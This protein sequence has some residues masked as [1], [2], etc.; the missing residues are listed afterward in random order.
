MYRIIDLITVYSVWCLAL[1]GQ[2]CRKIHLAWYP[3][4]YRPMEKSSRRNLY[5]P[6]YSLPIS[7]WSEVFRG[8]ECEWLWIY[9]RSWNK[10][11]S[12]L[13]LIYENIF[14]LQVYI[15]SHWIYE[16]T[17]SKSMFNEWMWGEHDVCY[18]GSNEVE[19]IR[20]T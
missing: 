19:T 5:L 17:I 15:I 14:R 20:A 3:L 4:K 7:R 16:P 1:M 13:F 10:R 9:N 18:H 6:N 8:Y 11:H 2:N 12:S